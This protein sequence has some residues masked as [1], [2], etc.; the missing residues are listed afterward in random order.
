MGRAAWV[1]GLLLGL[2]AGF[3]FATR[4]RPAAASPPDEAGSAATPAWACTFSIVAYDPEHKQWGV[5]VASKYLAVG[6]A[7]P[8]ARAGAGAVAT[9]ALVNTTYGSQGLELL[10]QGK[11]AAEVVKHVTDLDKEREARQVGIVDAQGEVAAFSGAGCNAWAGHKIGKHYTCQGNLL[12]GPQVVE[13]MARAFE[14]AKGPFAWRLMASLEAGEK[15]GGDK[16]GKQSAAILVVRAGGGP[17]G[18]GDRAIDFRV[19]DHERPVQELARILALRLERPRKA[20]SD[21]E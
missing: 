15:A 11:S 4:H 9:Q 7:V 1:L 21:H 10:A 17:N 5:A 13:A 6:S 8:W 12:A 19:D 3:A 16:R 20:A 14:E 18:L 2:I